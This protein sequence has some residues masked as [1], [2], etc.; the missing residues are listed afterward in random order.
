[1][2]RTVEPSRFEW[3][4]VSETDTKGTHKYLYFHSNSIQSELEI[5]DSNVIFPY[6]LYKGKSCMYGGIYIVQTLSSND[7]EILSICSQSTGYIN[8]ILYDLRNVSIVII[9]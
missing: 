6:M 1:M 9:H 2:Y 3:I 4:Y 7:T 8:T 5:L